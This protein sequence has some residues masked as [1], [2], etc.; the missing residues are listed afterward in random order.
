LTDLYERENED[1]TD[2]AERNDENDGCGYESQEVLPSPSHSIDLSEE[3][4]KR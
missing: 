4:K 3:R 1:V 2:R